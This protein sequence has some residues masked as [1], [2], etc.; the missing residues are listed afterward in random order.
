MDAE[1]VN[2]MVAGSMRIRAFADTDIVI[3][4]LSD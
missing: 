2:K 4:A 1:G 3:D